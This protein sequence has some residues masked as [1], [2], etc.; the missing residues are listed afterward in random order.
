MANRGITGFGAFVPALRIDRA[1]IAAATSWAFPSRRGKGARALANWDEDCVTMAVEAARGLPTADVAELVLASTTAPFAD[2]QNAT[3][4]SAALGLGENVAT[5]DSGGSLRAST[6]ALHVALTT[7]RTGTSVVVAA[8]ARKARPGSAQELAYGAGAVAFAIGGGPV[9][10][11]LLAAVSRSDLFVDHFRSARADYDYYWE[12]R[13]VRDEGYAKIVAPAIRAALDE[14]GIKAGDIDHFC[15]PAQQAAIPA[16]IAKQ[17]GIKADAIADNLSTNCGDTGTAHGP[18]MLAAAL[19]RAK[20]G[21]RL[22]V[23]GFGAGCD[24]LLF[25]TTDALAAYTPLRGVA[26]TLAAGRVEPHYSKMLSF[27]GELDLDW[28]MRAEGSEKIPPTQQYRARRQLATFTAGECPD[29]GTIQFPQ[30][31][32]CINCGSFAELA[33]RSLVDVPAKIASFTADWLQFH[34]SPPL[35][36]GLVQFDNGAR[37]MM[38][39]VDADPNLLEVGMPLRMVYRIKSIDN[40]RDYLR[41]FWKATP[42]ATSKEN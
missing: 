4:V 3:L 40:E 21:E 2:L 14:A 18:L 19:E 32:A 5:S 17:V 39:I 26:A 11:R 22:M 23:V 37:V 31:A 8:D 25:E 33:P 12:D 13:W 35:M 28:G 6:S 30:L 7:T 42:I 10:A 16:A 15:L 34:P 1:V 36:F 41:Y 9:I 27:Q 24:V 20:P 38:E 29:C